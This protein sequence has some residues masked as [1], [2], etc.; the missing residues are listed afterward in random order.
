MSAADENAAKQHIEGIL[1]GTDPVD[2]GLQSLRLVVRTL[3]AKGASHLEISDQI[4]LSLSGPLRIDSTS[5]PKLKAATE[6][7]ALLLSEQKELSA[8]IAASAR[9]I[10]FLRHAA[11]AD[12][13]AAQQQADPEE[14]NTGF[15]HSLVKV[16]RK[17]EDI[18]VQSEEGVGKPPKTLKE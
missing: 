18:D 13:R 14:A 6:R 3:L 5:E 7:H 10:A 17:R 2:R 15:A 1:A 4:G 11:K 8:R 9:E 12:A 16:K